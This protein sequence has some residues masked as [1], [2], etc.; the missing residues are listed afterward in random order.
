MTFH[1]NPETF[2]CH[3]YFLIFVAYL[4]KINTFAFVFFREKC[5]IRDCVSYT[6]GFLFTFYVVYF[7]LLGLKSSKETFPKARTIDILNFLI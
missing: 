4:L 1:L 6:I 7:I 2:P 5:F 3:F